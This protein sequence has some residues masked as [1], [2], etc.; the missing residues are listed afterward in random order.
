MDIEHIVSRC[1]ETPPSKE[2]ALFLFRR[3]RDIAHAGKIF[4][5]AA[6]VR[7]R[8][9][10]RVFK[11]DSE[12]APVV[13][14]R[15]APF[16]RYCTFSRE[17]LDRDEVLEG[18]RIAERTGIKD[19][20]LSGGS[21]L[22]SDGDEVVELVRLVTASTP[23]RVHVNIGPVYSQQNLETLKGLGVV[24][25]GS[26]L[27]TI[28]PSV[29]GEAKPGDSLKLRI[30]TAQAINRAGLK[31][32][33]I[34]MVGLGSSDE[35]YVE[36]LFFLKQLENLTH[37][38]IS[39]FNPFKGTPME[40]RRRASPFEAARLCAMARLVLRTPDIRIAAGGGPDDIP[41]WLMAGG[42]RITSLFIHQ[43]KCEP[44]RFTGEN[45]LHIE[46]TLADNLE[47]VDRSSICRYFA[48]EAG[49][50]VYPSGRTAGQP[51]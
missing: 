30:Q 45:P 20:R 48:E 11:L 43:S 26:S 34:I 33:S 12:I 35:D 41:L 29:F 17:S 18:L 7:D 2:E 6:E 8:E 1:L 13:P 21:D 39:R 32:Q 40:S 22:S 24:E 19:I 28:N 31:L 4:Q 42:N 27:E 46:R 23:L 16:C 36:H 50:E 38:P 9:A 14:C 10:G 5:A 3:S 47:V 25:V 44:E 49:F 51:S 15:I 37:L